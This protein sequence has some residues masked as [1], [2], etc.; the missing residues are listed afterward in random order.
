MA[1]ETEVVEEQQAPGAARTREGERAGEGR[2][3]ASPGA[4]EPGRG[5]QPQGRES[6]GARPQ[7][8]R[9]QPPGDEAAPRKAV[10]RRFRIAA[11][12]AVA[13][14]A[15]AGVLYWL[16]ARQYEDTDDAQVDGDIHP[17]S[18]RVNGTVIWVNPEVRANQF[19]AAGTE[20]VNIDPG[21]FRAAAASAQAEVDRLRANAAASGAEV[22]VQSANAIGQLRVAEAAVAQAR[23][24]VGTELANLNSA[25]SRVEQAQATRTW[26]E[27][28]RERYSNLL[29]KQEI[30]RSEYD[31]R[32]TAART[33]QA[34]L[35]AAMA[36]VVAAEARVAQARAAVAQQE[37]NL[38]KARTAPQ[39]IAEVRA[40]WGSANADLARAE[41]Q[42]QMARL[43]LSYTHLLAP[44]SGI[45]ANKSVETGQRVQPGQE[46]LT[47]VQL[48]HVWV[49]ADF[50]ETQLRLMRPGQHAE[51]HVD[52]FGVDLP[53]HV[54]SIAPATG[55]RFS[56]LPPE[57]ASGNF[58]KVVQ[59][60]PV[61]IRLDHPPD[62]LR[63]LRPGMSVD[64]AV[65][66]R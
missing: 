23:Q 12:A 45:V 37:A 30:S 63:P 19:V 18:A 39:Q 16:H 7:G 17:I 32:V 22:P 54:E 13:V 61:R 5:P 14:L 44:I 48:D 66:V 6:G 20:M 24:A 41:A 51:V 27:S 35:D 56:L 21:D 11:L 4:P 29:A 34:V 49:T 8:Q 58:V 9:P 57:N 3:P 43:N 59:R 60:L 10:P 50:K 38:G 36:D 25:K 31:Q 2:P 1:P 33:A 65:K 42:L 26:A 47:I 28:D 55:A 40:R 64:V 46:L 52:A 53:G 15:V 62:P